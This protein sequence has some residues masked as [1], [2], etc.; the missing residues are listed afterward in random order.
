MTTVTFHINPSLHGFITSAAIF[1][2]FWP[3]PRWILPVKCGGF[4]LYFNRDVHE[5][6]KPRL[7]RDP[8]CTA[9]IRYETLDFLSKTRLRWDTV[10][11]KQ[12]WNQD[13]AAPKTL[14]RKTVKII[15]H[16]KFGSS[17]L[18]CGIYVF[19]SFSRHILETETIM[20]CT[21][22]LHLQRC[23]CRN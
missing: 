20:V 15:R 21:N 13:V 22:D 18:A 4:Q 10:G 7:K 3:G 1:S 19:L 17:S 9:S 12:D 16:H 8:R 14:V 11:L 6:F 23:A 5:I 2:K